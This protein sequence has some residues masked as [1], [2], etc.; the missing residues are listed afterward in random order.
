FRE[1]V[2]QVIT[3]GRKGE[4]SIEDQGHGLFTKYLVEGLRGHANQDGRG[5]VLAQQLASWLCARVVRESKG[6]MSP[7]YARVDG[8]G[9]FIFPLPGQRLLVAAHDLSGTFTGTIQARVGE[10]QGM[11]GVTATLVQKGQ[12]LSGTWTTPVSSGTMTGI[13]DGLQ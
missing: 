13:V 12:N 5:F 6:R 1:P 4:R 9:S 2:V 8:E 3:A 11:T 7:Q 10:Q